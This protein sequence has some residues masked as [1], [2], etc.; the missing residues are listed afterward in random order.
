MPALDRTR[1]LYADLAKALGTDSLPPDNNNAI[2]LTIGEQSL[3]LMGED[4]ITMLIVAPVAELPRTLDYGV[5]L[6][7]LSRNLYNSDISPFT[8][9]CDASG[10]V[11]LWARIALE[12]QTGETL[13]GLLDAVAGEAERTFKELT[14]EG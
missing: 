9:A 4:D 2:Q 7:L 6:W 14:G 5:V 13:A 8:A 12:G 10:N 11:L 3:V 1:A